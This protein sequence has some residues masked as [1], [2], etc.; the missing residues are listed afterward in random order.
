M[1][2]EI[3][4][5]LNKLLEAERSGVK[6][7]DYLGEIITN[8]EIKEGMKTVLMDEGACCKGLY[9][10]IIE[11]GGTPVTTTGDFADKVKAT[12]GEKE[13]LVLLNKGQGWVAK[14]VDELISMVEKENVLTFL[15][16]MK[17]D[18]VCNIN[19]LE[20]KLK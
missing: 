1:S 13:K 7:A 16:K 11:Y 5:R 12:E 10:A 8:K 15:K 9:D 14:K 20:E 18:H 17:E 6:T 2:Q 19:W 3:I 4:E